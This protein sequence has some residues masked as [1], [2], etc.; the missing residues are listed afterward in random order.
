MYFVMS[1]C[2][3]LGGTN[4]IDRY[5]SQQLTGPS[6]LALVTCGIIHSCT[7]CN[8]SSPA[9]TLATSHVHLAVNSKP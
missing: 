1:N 2:E 5:T 7:Q 3:L 8:S 6:S 9:V 4:P